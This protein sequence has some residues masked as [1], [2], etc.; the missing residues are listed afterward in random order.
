MPPEQQLTIQQAIRLAMQHHSA[1]ELSKA[2]SM[3]QQILNAEPNQ[4]DALHLLGVI[5]YQGG[6]SNV[7]VEMITSAIAIRPDYAE[8]YL[9]L[10]NA[11]KELGRVEEAEQSY[12][13]SIELNPSFTDAHSNLGVLLQETG[14]VQ[15]AEQSY[16]KALVLNPE[17]AE[18]Q[19]NL[20]SVLI[21]TGRLEEAEQSCRRSLELNP[22]FAQAHSNL[23]VVLME[24]GRLEEAEQSYRRAL[25][26][27]PNGAAPLSDLALVVLR[28]GR[29]SEAAS[30]LHRALEIDPTSVKA[31]IVLSKSQDNLVP[32]WHVPMMNDTLR[33]EAYL[34]AL[35]SAITTDSK[36]FE[37]G[38]GSG[39]I[40]MM[41]ARL[42]ATE[43]TTC[44]AVELIAAAAKEVVAANGLA[45]SVKVLPKKSTDVVVGDDIAEQADILVS[46]ILSSEFLGEAVLPS[47]EDAKS[48]LLKPGGQIIPGAGSVMIAL[49][50]GDSIGR[51]VRVDNACGFDLS[52]FN[53]ITSNKLHILRYDLDIDLL[54][55]DIEA[56][57]FDFN[58]QDYFPADQKVLR[59]PVRTAGRCFGLIQ[60]NR[61]QMDDEVVFENHPSLRVDESGWSRVIYL[62]PE[63]I[64][65]EPGQTAVISA[66][67]DRQT[68]WFTLENLENHPDS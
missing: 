28:R 68:P 27:N 35:R 44:E 43:V 16:R 52:K 58:A 49:F 34:A 60:W 61:M 31:Q 22:N 2:E 1:G 54:S 41:A 25:E 11:F 26:L 65:A 48:R 19:N 33:N 40:A 23:G 42:G 7:A 62:F 50:G 63:P 57:N 13:R 21:E 47:I 56:F 66:T 59:I 51:N 36:V 64:D 38:T 17:F 20:S 5:A 10:G 4:P 55:D 67:H 32:A 8:A 12:R 39:L 18:A 14:Q 24:T 29:S 46:E 3:Y 45:D 53:E 30:Y 37:I 15:E 6:K 9:N